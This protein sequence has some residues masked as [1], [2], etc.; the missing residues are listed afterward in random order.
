MTDGCGAR[1]RAESHDYSVW[2][3]NELS[4]GEPP[5]SFDRNC[6][7]SYV[8][9]V[10]ALKPNILANVVLMAITTLRITPQMDFDSFFM[11]IVDLKF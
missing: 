7:I 6:L 9:L 2:R 11:I 4:G 8:Y 1:H 5:D 3:C 10:Q